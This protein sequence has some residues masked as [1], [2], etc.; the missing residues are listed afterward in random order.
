MT[1]AFYLALEGPTQP[2]SPRVLMQWA[3]APLF[4]LLVVVGKV[5]TTD[6]LRQRGM[7]VENILD[8]FVL[9]K[10]EEESI[11][12]QFLHCEVCFLI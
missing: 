9:C 4:C 2:R 12:H 5:S 6:T 10:K 3:L 11:N 8:I 1:K 7:V